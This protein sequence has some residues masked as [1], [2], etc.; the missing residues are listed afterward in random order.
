MSQS[1]T[2][3]ASAPFSILSLLRMVWIHKFAILAGWIAVSVAAYFVVMRMPPVYTAEAFILVDAQKIPERF[4]ASTVSGDI[5]DRLTTISQ[6]ILTSARL[7]K[8]IDDYDL[9]REERQTHVF[10]EVLQM[11]RTDISYKLERGWTNNKPGAF[12]VGFQGPDAAVVAQ[13][14]NRLAN[15][16]I[17][18]N[19]RTR[20][21][22]AEGTS[23][24]LGTLVEEAKKKLDTL[25]ATVS[26]YKVRHNGELPEQ[27]G[28]LTAAL[29]RLQMEQN[30]NRDA[31]ARARESKSMLE[32]TLHL[33]ESS[34]QALSQQRPAASNSTEAPRDFTALPAGQA[35][36]A[37][38]RPSDT[39]RA[40]LEQLRARYGEA[41]PDVKRLRVEL[42]RALKAE[43]VEDAAPPPP[44]VTAA[45]Q[46]LPAPAPRPV[47]QANA[48]EIGQARERVS[49][50]KAQIANTQ[51]EIEGRTADQERMQ[52]E[53]TV[54]QS[55]LTNVPLRE[56][57]MQQIT[58]DYEITKGNYRSLLDKQISAE[59]STDMER[60]QKS[61]RFTI[62]DPA[63]IPEKP[64]KPNRPFFFLLGSA[65]GIMMSLS[66]AIGQEIRKDLMMG[67]WEMPKGV[68]VLGRVPQ[69]SPHSSGSG[70]GFWS[71]WSLTKRLVLVSSLLFGL[72]GIVAIQF[73]LRHRV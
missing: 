45:A 9:Y 64:T 70:T 46:V 59:M 36:Q 28:A 5:Q 15:L 42:A 21:V 18:E 16:Y 6:G 26:A 65:C 30:G 66:L 72:L 41:H 12:R 10:E 53:L 27:Q 67:E 37:A 68:V 2:A 54:Y 55:K 34:L 49:V 25:E 13:V 47:N 22:Q 51:K 52:R 43:A 33:A 38:A 17:E 35:A 60:R 63:R 11:M 1:K 69:I 44:P 61:E 14:A 31:L 57:E 24:F 4:V 48:F 23:E 71:S 50:I 40:Q 3:S 7:K 58:R 8:I 29:N 73:F 62:I 39:L 32:N 20:E 19:L 56:Q